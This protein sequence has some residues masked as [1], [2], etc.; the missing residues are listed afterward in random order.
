MVATLAALVLVGGTVA[1]ALPGRAGLPEDQYR[2]LLAFATAGGDTGSRVLLFGPAGDLPGTSRDFEGLGYRVAQPALPGVLGRLLWRSRA[3]ATRPWRASS[4]NC[5]AARCAAPGSDS[6]PSASAGWPSPR[7]APWRTSSRRNSTWCRLRGLAIPVFRNEVSATEAY[8]PGRHRLAA[9]RHRLRSARGG[10]GRPGLRRHERRL[11]L[12]AGGVEPGRL[13]QPGRHCR[14]PKCASPAMP[15]GATWRWARR[16]GWPCWS[17][18]SAWGGG[19]GG[20]RDE[21]LARAVGGGG[22]GGR[23]LPAARA[24]TPRRSR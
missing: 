3:W 18:W 10:P 8:G 2:D 7:R 23:G 17:C 1:V 14:R 20:G 24:R 9:R 4:T 16:P 19:G 22:G 15:A 5:S 12:G 21:T 6:P 13:G 11:P